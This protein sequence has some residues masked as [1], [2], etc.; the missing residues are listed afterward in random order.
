MFFQR[1]ERLI[2][3][4]GP[5]F[6]FKILKE[7]YRVTV[8]R[9]AGNPIELGFQCSPRLR[10]DKDGLPTLYPKRFREILMEF[11]TYDPN[12]RLS[13]TPGPW[14]QVQV[15]PVEVVKPYSQ[16]KIVSILSIVSIFRVLS[17]SVA[18]SIST[19]TGPFT[20]TSKSF[21]KTD[22]LDGLNNFVPPK[23]RFDIKTMTQVPVSVERIQ[24]SIGKFSPHLSPKSGPNGPLSTLCSGLD[25]LAFMHDP[26]RF[27]LLVGWMMDQKAYPWILWFLSINF[28]FGIPYILWYKFTNGIIFRVKGL[29]AGY[30]RVYY[31]PILKPI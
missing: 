20:G 30:P 3:Y 25:A 11:V 4:N 17:T 6:A 26:K 21:P 18:V 22:I 2:Y 8:Q 13:E 10:L 31:S 29:L 23:M 27:L 19:I 5:T 15:E 24:V 14:Y 16:S 7:S 28:I 9:L 12:V 1:V